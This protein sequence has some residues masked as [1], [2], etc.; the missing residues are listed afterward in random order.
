MHLQVFS[1]DISRPDWQEAY[2]YNWGYWFAVA[3]YVAEYM[4]FFALLLAASRRR[5]HGVIALLVMAAVPFVAYCL[6]YALRHEFAIKTNFSLNYSLIVVTLLELALDFGLLPSY[7]WHG[8]AFSRL[9]LDLKV[10][11]RDGSVAFATNS[12]G[13]VPATVFDRSTRVWRASTGSWRRRTRSCARRCSRSARWPRPRQ[14]C[15]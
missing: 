2:V 3:V 6:M 9:P 10:L 7:S 12:A 14:S 5:L 13:P 4:G 1:F 15:A 8:E 11:E